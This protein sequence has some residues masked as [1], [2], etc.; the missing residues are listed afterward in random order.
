MAAY[1]PLEASPLE[2]GWGGQAIYTAPLTAGG[3]TVLQALRALQALDWARLAPA[4][5]THA[6]I[7]ALR[8]AWRDRLAFFG[9]PRHVHVPLERLLSSD[10]ARECAARIEAAIKAGKPLEL[11]AAAPKNHGGTISLSA[12]DRNG[13]LAVVTLTHGSS[14]GAR[15]TIEGM[16]LTLGHGMSRFDPEPDHPN[17]PGPGKRPLHNMCPTIVARDGQ[18]FLAVGGRGGRRIVNAV[19]DFL[20]PLV[21]RRRSP[22]EA[23]ATLRLHTEGDQSVVLEPAW[24]DEEAETLRKL[25]LTVTRGSSA[26]LSAAWRDPNSG[27]C[28]SAMR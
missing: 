21:A 3:A 10:Y 26:V 5:Q 25:G 22:E 15:V 2:L 8:L 18:P 20:L 16:G 23:M 7:E 14:F 28:R 27:D 17:A 9:D 1:R 24:P 13:M 19:F 12:V 4:V 11:P 6:R